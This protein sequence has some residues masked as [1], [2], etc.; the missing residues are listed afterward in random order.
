[1]EC[2]L[3]KHSH[4]GHFLLWILLGA[5]HSS[6]HPCLGRFVLKRRSMDGFRNFNSEGF[7]ATSSSVHFEKSRINILW[8]WRVTSLVK[9]D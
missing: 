3:G 1:M 5:E 7:V 8:L 4:D 2:F 6:T 9:R